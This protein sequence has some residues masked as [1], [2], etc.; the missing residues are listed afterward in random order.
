MFAKRLVKYH[1]SARRIKRRSML[2]MNGGGPKTTAKP[3]VEPEL[4]P[5]EV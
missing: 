1:V 2:M 4:G 3:G 5:F